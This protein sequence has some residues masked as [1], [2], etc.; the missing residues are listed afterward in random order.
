V[1]FRR[2]VAVLEDLRRPLLGERQERAVASEL[3]PHTGL[4]QVALGAVGLG[5]SFKKCGPEPELGATHVHKEGE[6]K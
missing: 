4:V 3:R 1:R 5:V 6:S 2:K